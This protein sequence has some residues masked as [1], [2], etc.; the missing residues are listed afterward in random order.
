MSDSV[1][2]NADLKSPDVRARHQKKKVYRK[3]KL[4]AA[5]PLMDTASSPQ[6]PEKEEIEYERGTAAQADVDQSLF[7]TMQAEHIHLSKQ[8]PQVNSSKQVSHFSPHL[9]T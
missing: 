9:E 6:F 2:E 3:K 4:G 1:L 7:E 8:S 5:R